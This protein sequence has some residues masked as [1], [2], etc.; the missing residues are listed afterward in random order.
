MYLLQDRD[1]QIFILETTK[2]VYELFDNSDIDFFKK[3]NIKIHRDPL[4]EN[5]S[6]I[7]PMITDNKIIGEII[8]RSMRRYW[9]RN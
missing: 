7:I 9:T 1:K 3:N 2:N 5:T 6:I 4:Q 8:K